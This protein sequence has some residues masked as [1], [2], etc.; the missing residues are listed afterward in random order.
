MGEEASSRRRMIDCSIVIRNVYVML[1]Y[2]FRAMHS[3]G[4][5]RIAAERFEHLH[6]LLAEELVRGVGRQVKRGL[7]RDYLL[8][9]D[10]LATVR[11]RINMSRNVATRSMI[12]GRLACEFD[13]YELDNL[14]NRALKAVIVLLL[15][16]GDVASRR[17]DALRWLLPYLDAVTLVAPTSIRW[18]SLSYH[19]ANANYRL[20]LGVCELIVRG[21]LPTQDVGTAK[22][23]SWMSDDAMS[24]LYERFLREYFS[25]HHP[26]LFPAASAVAWDYDEMSALGADQLPAMRTDATL[27]RGSRTLIIDAKYYGQSMQIGMWGKATVHS[28]NL[29]QVLTYA[30]NADV[31][32]DRSVSGLLLYART[33]APEQPNLDVVIQGN[34]IGALTVDLNRPWV[35]LRAQLE[36]V[37]NWLDR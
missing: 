25:A 9:R 10:E 23:S 11:G 8:R 2:A 29:Y 21:L 18:N 17:K 22:L 32:Q 35:E 15:R 30:K 36:D 28:T 5:D 3:E 24:Q 20:L 37:V 31:A 33:A 7:H 12:R 27:R 14:Y 19:R 1:A 4:S 6:D 13:K 16:H 34:R 26:E